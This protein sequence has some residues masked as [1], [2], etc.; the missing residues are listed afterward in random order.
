MD[1][2]GTIAM[3]ESRLK[4]MSQKVAQMIDSWNEQTRGIHLGPGG[5]LFGELRD[6]R[7]YSVLQ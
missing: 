1:D 6:W 2:D 4:L 7:P 3:I 5:K